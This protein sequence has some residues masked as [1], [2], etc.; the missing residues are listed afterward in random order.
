M[1]Q[2]EYK[3]LLRKAVNQLKKSH[4]PGVSIGTGL[5]DKGLRNIMNGHTVR[6][7]VS[8]LGK[9]IEHFEEL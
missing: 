1:T 9:I 3:K 8:T 4:I 2:T 5:S 6:P 7:R